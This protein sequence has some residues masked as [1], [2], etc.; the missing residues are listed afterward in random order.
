MARQFTLPTART[1]SIGG[2]ARISTLDPDPTVDSLV[3]RHA[4]ARAT[5]SSRPTARP[6]WSAPTRRADSRGSRRRRPRRP[7]TANPA[8]SWSPGLGDQVGN[9]VEYRLDQPVTFDHLDLQVVAD[10]KHSI[11]T[12]ITVTTPTASRTVALPAIAPGTG[13]TQGSVTPVP[14]S[15]PALTGS[16]VKITIDAVRTPPVPRLPLEQRQHRPGGPGRG[17]H[18][19]RGPG[20]DAGG[21][22]RHLLPRP[23][24]G[25]RSTGR[26]RDHRLD[27]P[28]PWPTGA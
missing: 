22:T 23:G 1:F 16:D 17:G 19:R 27:Q 7:S 13:R 9:W 5:S 10:G 26:H 11:P 6:R 21:G 20:H 18:P 15:F 14:V 8:T 25:G 3:G 12:A 2:T 4:R 28:P 24:G